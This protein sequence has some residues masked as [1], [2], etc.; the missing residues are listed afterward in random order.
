VGT[1]AA[2]AVNVHT[3]NPP[4]ITGVVKGSNPFRR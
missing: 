1:T 3:I 2:E 4:A